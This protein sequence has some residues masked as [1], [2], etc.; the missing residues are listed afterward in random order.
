MKAAVLVNATARNAGAIQHAGKV[1][2]ADKRILVGAHTV[3]TVTVIV[4]A[5]A[6]ITDC[7]ILDER[8]YLNFG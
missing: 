1:V 6:Q 5:F 3:T 8:I 2:L 4:I 7:K